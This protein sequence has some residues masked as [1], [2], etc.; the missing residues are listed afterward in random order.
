MIISIDFSDMNVRRKWTVQECY[1]MKQTTLTGSVKDFK[2]L[3]IILVN[4]TDKEAAWDWMVKNYHYL[5][6][7]K[8]IG[9]RVKYL[10][11]YAGTPI[12]ALSYNRAALK[13][14]V[15]D[16]YI[17][18]SQ[19]QKQALLKHVVSNNRFLI[20]PWVKIKNLASHLLS[21]TLKMLKKDWPALFGDKPYIIETFVDKEKFKGTCYIAANW[22]Y[23]GETKGY[24]K[25]GKT[26]VY[27]G[28][29][30]GVYIYILNQAFIERIRQASCHQSLKTVKR[31]MPTMMLQTMDWSPGILEEAGVTSEAVAG[32]GAMLG[33][34]L[35]RYS[36]CFARSEQRGHAACYAKGL[37][38]DLERKSIEPIALRYAGPGEVRRMQHFTQGGIW[39]DAGM[40]AIYQ[41]H[42]SSIV[43]DPEGM[44]TVDGCDFQKKGTESVGVARQYCGALGKTENCQAGVFVGY[45]GANGYGLIDKSLY[46]PEKWFEDSYAERREKCGVPE[47]LTF[48][49]KPQLASDMIRKTVAYGLFPAKWL[50]CDASFGSNKEF[51]DSIPNSLYYFADIHSN[52]LAFLSMPEI[53]APPYGGTGRKNLKPRPSFAPVPVANIAADAT[54]PWESVTLGE[55]AKG[56]IVADEKCVRVV[57]CREGLPSRWQWL[58]IRRLSD[59]SLKFSICN[60]PADTPVETLRKMALMRWP[61]EQC[62]EECKSNLGMDHYEG[63]SWNLWHRHMA[64]VFIVHLFLLELRLLFK[65][66][67]NFNASPS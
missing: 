20:L 34:Y 49:T 33:E 8:T 1:E 41:A 57:D 14:G 29:R 16:D 23:L 32:L 27:H 15:R 36:G 28:K 21:Q 56:P 44:I 63:R 65:K 22:S 13:I 67:S 24:G 60:A 45:S 18:W 9:P 35:E 40:L 17:G 25:I 46:V 38:S 11:L 42:L 7:E 3:E 61:I 59:S 12:A 43:S 39:D 51:L 64:F 62:F 26:F 50:G 6:Y 47:G 19:E 2:P 5:G 66:N 10:V 30:K 48:K 37:L 52:M 55:G 4:K 31:K 54:I 53:S 58:Y